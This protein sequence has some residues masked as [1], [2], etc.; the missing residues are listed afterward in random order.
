MLADSGGISRV[1]I[2]IATRH[3]GAAGVSTGDAMLI[4]QVK[5]GINGWTAITESSIACHTAPKS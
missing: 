3:N 4:V 5:K 2:R 1:T